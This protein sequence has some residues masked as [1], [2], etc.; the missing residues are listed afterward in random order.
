MFFSRREP[1]LLV[2][3]PLDII[4][5]SDII[6]LCKAEVSPMAELFGTVVL[7]IAA[8]FCLVTSWSSAVAPGQFAERLGLAVASAGGSNEI[9]AQYAGFFLAV[10]VLCAAALGGAVPRQ[11]GFIV[12]AVV[13]GGLIAGRLVSLALDRGVAGYGPTILALYA[14]DS[15]GFA[16]AV[17][18]LLLDRLA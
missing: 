10:A 7:A 16:L 2:A 5:L 14:I 15:L 17:A 12:L 3:A 6:G 8:L 18:A 1:V 9:R 13:F 11:A 4:R